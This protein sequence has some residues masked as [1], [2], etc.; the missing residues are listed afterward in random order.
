MRF[1]LPFLLIF[2]IAACS[3]DKTLPEGFKLISID[4]SSYFV[5]MDQKYVGDKTMQREVGKIVCVDMYNSGDYCDVYFWT[6]LEEIP[7]KFPIVNRKSMIGLFQMRDNK[8]RLKPLTN[9][10][11]DTGSYR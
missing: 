2:A 5:H 7:R 4:G 10:D 3:E 6:N 9:N 8:L 11:K 1:V